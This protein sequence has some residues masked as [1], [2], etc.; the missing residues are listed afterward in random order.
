MRSLGLCVLCCCVCLGVS[1]SARAADAA[2]EVMPL[3]SIEVSGLKLGASALYDDN[4]TR[5]DSDILSDESLSVSLD[6][7][8]I[9]PLTAWMRVV[10]TGGVQFEHFNHWV[11]LSHADLDAG[12]QLQYRP[13]PSF[14]A[15]IIQFGVSARALGYQDSLRSGGEYIA[16]LTAFEA[17]TDQIT[18]SLGAEHEERRAE[19]S[20][21]DGHGDRVQIHVDDSL[22]STLTLYAGLARRYGDAVT[23]SF[24]DP[25]NR[26]IALAFAPDPAFGSTDRIAYRFKASSI[27]GTLGMN[28]ALAGH[29]SLDLSWQ[30]VSLF[31]VRLPSP[32]ST[33]AKYVDNQVVLSYLVQF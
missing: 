9:L 32:S 30:K 31:P 11:G 3:P 15:P 23:S 19:N 20:T 21:F 22:S 16:N 7:S 5:S 18:A 29:Q 25:D 28:Y 13:A 24:R 8:V 1:F 33:Q 17:L 14:Y 12:A 4:V 26:A 10:L 2:D 27:V 6:D